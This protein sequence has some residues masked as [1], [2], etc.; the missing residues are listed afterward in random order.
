[1]TPLDALCPIPFHDAGPAQRARILSRLADTELFVAL[2]HEP[3]G[4]RAELQVFALP[5]GA[6][7]LAC[8]A[9][10]RL[11][12][13]IGGPVAYLALPGRVLAAALQAEGQGALI[14]PGHASEM[15][16]DAATLDWLCRA[17]QVQPSLAP[18]A[19]PA[20]ARP[21]APE[22]VA[23]LAEPL[24][25]RL[26]DLGAVVESAA[27]IGADWADG[28]LAHMLILTGVDPAHRAAVAKA[29]AELLAFLPEQDGGIDIGFSQAPHPDQALILQAPAPEP[30]A[31]APQRD[32][33]APPRLRW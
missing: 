23:A 25:Q 28:R 10:D 4:D 27:L 29:F 2:T 24:G 8:D 26:G 1:M 11:A 19:A 32:P 31:P 3:A 9:E 33:A 22:L 12:G 18:D 5:E 6:V 16:L 14:N 21:P 15:L 13:F 17:L 30:E 20:A 7:A